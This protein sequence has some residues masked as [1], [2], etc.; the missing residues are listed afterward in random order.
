[1]PAGLPSARSLPYRSGPLALPGLPLTLLARPMDLDP[2]G[3]V[4]R[5]PETLLV[6]ALKRPVV[7]P[8]FAGF[9]AGAERIGILIPDASRKAGVP[10]LLGG[11]AEV[12]KDLAPRARVGVYVACGAHRPAAAAELP[13]LAGDLPATSIHARAE[14]AWREVGTTR[15]GTPVAWPE[16]IAGACRLVSIG[17][18]KHHYFAGFGG[19]PKFLVPGVARMDTLLANHGLAFAPDGA[20]LR[21]GIRPGVLER[22]PLH[23]D[24][25]EAAAMG[26]P[27]YS[28]HVLLGADGEPEAVVGGR[29]LDPLKV[30]A[31]RWTERASPGGEPASYPVVVASAGEPPDDLD[32]VQ[33][34]KGIDSAATW[35]APGGKLFYAAACPEGFG[36][37]GTEAALG[38]GPAEIAARMKHRFE[39]RGI[40]A[41][42]LA[43]KA[44]AFE[45]HL[46]SDLPGERVRAL[47][48]VPY[49]DPR[50]FVE[51]AARAVAAAGR[52]ALVPFAGETMPPLLERPCWMT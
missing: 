32:L 36:P 11:L 20:G 33:A 16:E 40:F 13:E 49:R 3:A 5:P 50:A 17:A 35:L 12:L 48:L 4:A 8:D 9:V 46:L 38:G 29:G 10:G 31:A 34:H 44:R 39:L 30:A 41:W 1:M 27:L 2:P 42:S 14:L 21:P 37:P 22:N 25:R 18:V 26:P 15:A 45:I 24:L 19:G 47:G 7:G 6:P 51:A 52:G 23:A 28:L 43:A